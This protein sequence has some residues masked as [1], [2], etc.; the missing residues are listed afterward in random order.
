MSEMEWEFPWPRPSSHF[1]SDGPT[2]TTVVHLPGADYSV[3]P[4][5]DTGV[6]SG[7][8]RFRVECLT[9]E[10]VLHANT[11]GPSVRIRQHQRDRHLA[12]NR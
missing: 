9:C 2:Q 4:T 1:D 12:E 3:E 11:T 5:G 8:D 10:T 7:R 6:D